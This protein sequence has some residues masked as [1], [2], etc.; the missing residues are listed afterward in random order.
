MELHLYGWEGFC[1]FVQS[2]SE[3]ERAGR[4][5]HRWVYKTLNIWFDMKKMYL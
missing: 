5:M 2:E 3:D 4:G 1:N